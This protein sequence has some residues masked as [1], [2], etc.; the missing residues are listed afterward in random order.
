MP[1]FVPSFNP[2]DGLAGPLQNQDV[3]HERDT[4]NSSIDDSLSGDRLAT[5][6]SFIGGDDHS[7]S[8]IDN[9]VAES[10][11]AESGEDHGVYGTNTG[12]C[13]E[14]GGGLPGH[15][16]VNRDSVALLNAK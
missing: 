16:K 5:T 10:L 12:T 11:G 3:F 7:A 2:R 15:G 6:T 13:E 8:A 14:R 9:S 1:P 4:G